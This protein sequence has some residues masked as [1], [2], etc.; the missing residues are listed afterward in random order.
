MLAIRFRLYP[1]KYRKSFFDPNSEKLI[2]DP[3]DRALSN[4]WTSQNIFQMSVR[5]FSHRNF[6][7]ALYKFF[8]SF[9]Q[10]WPLNSNF[11]GHNSPKPL[12]SHVIYYIGIVPD[13]Q[14]YFAM[15]FHNLMHPELK[16]D[17]NACSTQSAAVEPFLAIPESGPL[18][19]LLNPTFYQKNKKSFHFIFQK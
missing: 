10:N 8:G 16:N 11:T 4:L 14:R 5:V 13:F 9:V 6:S 12:L 15:D 19:R 17:L 1:W 3:V 2:F 18:I 7:S